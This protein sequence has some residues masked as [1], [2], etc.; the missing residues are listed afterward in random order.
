MGARG[1][2][3]GSGDWLDVSDEYIESGGSLATLRALCEKGVA[4]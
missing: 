1:G 3:G 4:D 2:G